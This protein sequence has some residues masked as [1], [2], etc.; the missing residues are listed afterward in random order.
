MKDVFGDVKRGN[1]RKIAGIAL[2]IIGI[3]GL[4]ILGPKALIGNTNPAYNHTILLKPGM[5][6]EIE[7]LSD[8]A[9]V[10]LIIEKGSTDRIEMQGFA[11]EQVVSKIKSSQ[12]TG[13]E[14][15]LDIR[16]N[17]VKL[18]NFGFYKKSPRHQIV[19]QLENDKTLEKLMVQNAL[20]EISLKGGK[21]DE[22]SLSTD[23]GD[24]EVEGVIG[25]NTTVSSGA[26]DVDLE[27]V[28]AII[29]VSTSMGNIEI[30]NSSK[31]VTTNT[32]MGNTNIE[33]KEPHGVDAKGDLGDIKIIV[34][35]GFNGIY[36]LDTDLG[37]IEK[38]DSLVGADTI[39]KAR[40]AMGNIK[41]K[42]N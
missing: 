31:L 32:A 17:T 19:V 21:I 29:Q 10:E 28:D 24:V 6:K 27:R 7:I 36:D 34:P 2:I 35:R 23:M 25:K 8:R 11:P 33:M 15:N 40:T 4:I 20:G 41:V 39:I 42:E 12:V 14:W 9:D 38:P 13:G 22:L 37:D 26:G 16:D 30:S 18:V 3:V 1:G 5:L